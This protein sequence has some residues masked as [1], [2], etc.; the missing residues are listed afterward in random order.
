M[1]FSIDL[2]HETPIYR[3]RHR[4]N[5]HEWELVNE[6]C[7]ELHKVGLI[8]PLSFDFTTITIMP[9]KKDLVGLWIKKKMCG[10]Y[11]PLNLV[12]P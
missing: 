9:T 1:Q 4:L 12:T 5:K 6:R 10:D 11:K 2:I 3:R 8:Q 7:K